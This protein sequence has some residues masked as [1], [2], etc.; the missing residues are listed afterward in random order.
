[1]TDKLPPNLLTLF[2]ARPAL[3]YLPPS[4]YAAEER[5]T[6]KISGVAQFVEYM[7]DYEK[8]PYEPTESWLQK[9]EGI[10][11]EKRKR[12]ESLRNN[13]DEK[14]TLEGP[15]MIYFENASSFRIVISLVNT[16]A[17]DHFILL[18]SCSNKGPQR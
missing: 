6:S 8:I 10:K 2:T 17:N 3:R 12:L 7:K 15:G 5:T 4:D 14:C 11:A 16:D 9:K 1:M 13:T 18:Y